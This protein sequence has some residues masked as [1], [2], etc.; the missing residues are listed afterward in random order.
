M[1]NRIVNV[2]LGPLLEKPHLVDTL[3]AY[4]TAE[5][6]LQR[7]AELLVVH[8]NTVAYRLRQIASLTGRDMRHITDMA[9]LIVGLTALDVVEMRRKGGKDRVDLRAHLL[10]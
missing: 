9:D 7:T 2:R 10:G 5:M 3:R 8:P 6:S 1:S 4:I